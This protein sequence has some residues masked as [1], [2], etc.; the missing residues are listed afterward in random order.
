MEGALVG[1]LGQ[2]AG[3]PAGRG[4]CGHRGAAAAHSSSRRRRDL[5]RGR[6]QIRSAKMHPCRPSPPSLSSLQMS[7]LSPLWVPRQ[8]QPIEPGP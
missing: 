7:S 2:T 6:Q 4:L 1:R 8:E 3:I 5:G